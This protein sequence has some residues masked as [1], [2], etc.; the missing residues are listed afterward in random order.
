MTAVVRE[1][2]RSSKVGTII[3][4]RVLDGTLRSDIPVK[5]IRD[6]EVITHTR[7]AFFR[8][9]TVVHALCAVKLDGFDDIQVDDVIETEEDQ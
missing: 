7:I 9:G 6:G 2:F 4:C 1:V 5:V 8:A 3:G